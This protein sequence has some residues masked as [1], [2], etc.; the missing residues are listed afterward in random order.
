MTRKYNEEKRGWF[1]KPPR[2]DLKYTL[3][4]ARI[5][6]PYYGFGDSDNAFIGL[7][8]TLRSGEGI[9]SFHLYD[10]EDIKQLL[11]QFYVR[12]VQDLEGKIVELF[13]PEKYSVAGFRVAE[14]LLPRR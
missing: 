10:E 5:D 4:T 6:D 2:S 7:H 14:H 9:S 13:Q 3:K 1:H 8:I 11:I 12:R